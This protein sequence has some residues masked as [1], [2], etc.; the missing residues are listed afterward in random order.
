MTNFTIEGIGL[1]AAETQ[2]RPVDEVKTTTMELVGT[3]NGKMHL[4]LSDVDPDTPNVIGMLFNGKQIDIRKNETYMSTN[5]DNGTGVYAFDIPM[6]FIHE[7]P[8]PATYSIQFLIGHMNGE[9]FIQ[10]DISD[11]YL[12]E[13]IQDDA[14]PG[15]Y[16]SD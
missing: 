15:T 11:V 6:R 14:L 1:T 8:K 2:V 10:E 4:K 5:T 16:E 12:L 13:V 9:E 7:V 3:T